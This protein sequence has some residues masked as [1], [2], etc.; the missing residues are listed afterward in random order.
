M[1]ATESRDSDAA[2]VPELFPPPNS[3]SRSDAFSPPPA[4]SSPLE[5]DGLIATQAADDR[6]TIA[7][8][9]N[10][11]RLTDLGIDSLS[12]R[13]IAEGNDHVPTW[14]QVRPAGP[15]ESVQA[16]EARLE[17][18]DIYE[19]KV[20]LAVAELHRRQEVLEHRK[21]SREIEWER[22]EEE[23]AKRE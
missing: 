10:H 11:V 1:G 22:Q 6:A 7:D 13:L 2:R 21:R 23:G 15:S 16:E 4:P 9:P 5:S 3:F 20:A 17:I 12:D 8:F 14:S 19:R 18:E